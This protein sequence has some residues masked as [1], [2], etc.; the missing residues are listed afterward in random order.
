MLEGII[1]FENFGMVWL[2]LLLVPMIGY[3]IW[4]TIKGGAAV[5]IST[6]APLTKNASKSALYYFR[7]IPF[8]L[9]TAAFAALVV[10]VM[11]PQNADN[12]SSSTAEGIDIA[13]A[14]DISTSMLARDFQPDR[15]GAAK[16]ISS[17]FIMERP[18]DRVA[19]V[20]FAGEAFTQ[21]PLTTDH[22]S[23]VSMLNNV[24]MGFIDDG[25]AIGNGLGVAV[26]RL[27]ESKAPS[28]VIVL[29]TDGVNN[30]GQIDPEMAADLAAEYGIRVY[31]IG[32]GTQGVAPYPAIDMWGNMVFQQAKV[33]IDEKLLTSIAEKSGGKYFRAT[34]N[35]TLQAVYNEINRL[36]KGKV[37]VENYTKYHDVFAP[38]LILALGL[39][40]LE[41]IIKYLIFRRL[42]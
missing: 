25:T 36:E 13:V 16:A 31:T 39:I 23:L 15:F 17:K 28:K 18:T 2:L 24:Q 20:V 3:Y 14:L 10:A 19:L 8:L 21:V 42:P 11:R 4:R 35:A 29:L 32:V 37:E 30:S 22:S 34:D 38:W 12:F 1:R 33:E 7:H 5:V 27:R 6:V 9:R 26:N 40:L 41:I